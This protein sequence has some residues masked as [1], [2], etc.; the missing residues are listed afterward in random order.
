[1]TGTSAAL[2]IF[3]VY[4]PGH[5]VSLSSVSPSSLQFAKAFA[6]LATALPSVL[7]FQKIFEISQIL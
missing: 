6:S 2:I 5:S 1:M 4:V 7:I 3:C